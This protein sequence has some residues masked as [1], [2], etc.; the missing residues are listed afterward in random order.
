MKVI[1]AIFLVFSTHLWSEAILSAYAVNTR[2]KEVVFDSQSDI[3]LIPASCLKIATT[4]AALHLLGPESD[5]QTHLE[6]DGDVK[7]GALHGNIWIRG[8]GDPCLGSGRMSSSLPWEEQIAVWAAAIQQ[9]GIKEIF[10]RIIGDT[11]LWEKALA[12]ASWAWEDLGNY[13][14]AGASALTFHENAYTI[15]FAPGQKE[16]DPTTLL[17]TTPPTLH[18]ILNEVKTGPIGSGDRACIYGSEFSVEQ[19]IRGTVPLGVS[20]FS[21]KGAIPDTAALCEKLLSQA[22]KQKGVQIHEEE[23]I[24]SSRRVAIHTTYSPTM[25]EIVYFTNQKSI[26]LYAEHL[27]KRIGQKM[28][29]DGS[30]ASGIKA[31]VEFWKERDIEGFNMVDGSGLSRKNFITTKQLTSMLI[32]MKESPHF[33]IFFESLPQIKEG[34]RA[35][36]GGMSFIGGYAGYKG[37]I[38]FAILIN[39]ATDRSKMRQELQQWMDKL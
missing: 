6:M 10:G 5:F 25:R 37:D 20:E 24:F 33:E 7:D 19:A 39:H 4:A 34:I 28:Y 36:D 32:K 30:T 17:R 12:P 35:K 14:G 11:T 1:C 21:I 31:I 9:Q 15:D 18:Q 2:T 16:G 26:N 38:A 22:L 8:G 29:R 13:Y 23:P 27:V 3:S